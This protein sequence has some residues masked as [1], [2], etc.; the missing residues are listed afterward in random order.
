MKLR[1]ENSDILQY[2]WRLDG[3]P[4]RFSV[5]LSL[6]DGAPDAKYPILAYVGCSSKK[7]GA[8]PGFLEKRRMDAFAAKCK[9][10][11][12]LVPVG[13]IETGT[14]RQYYFYL[15]SKPEYD[16]LKQLCEAEKGF[17]C[18]AGGKKEE[19]WGT[20]FRILYP[21]AA[22]YQTVRNEEILAQHYDL[23]DSDAPRRLN[24]HIAFKS[25]PARNAFIEAARQK[26]FAVG[27]FEEFD[28]TDLSAG[29]V[30]HRICALKKFDIDAL[31]VQVI[32]IA[33]EHEG[34]LLFWDCPIVPGR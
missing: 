19:D 34:R 27:E 6:Y 22:K 28:D 30:L 23:G 14:I 7:E 20:Y 8:Q 11:L 29:V 13:A 18:R 9:K 4:A 16:A 33:D 2:D 12:D 25:D 3:E 10:K 17:V 31:T 26:G 15:P 5:D 21:D 24:L 1:P 32:R